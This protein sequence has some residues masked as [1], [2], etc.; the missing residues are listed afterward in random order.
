MGFCSGEAAGTGLDY[1]SSSS[2]SSSSTMIMAFVEAGVGVLVLVAIA[3]RMLSTRT[4]IIGKQEVDG[5][6]DS[7]AIRTTSIEMVVDANKDVAV[8]V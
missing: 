2:A 6:M 4:I 5:S 7:M 1:I 3:A 8:S